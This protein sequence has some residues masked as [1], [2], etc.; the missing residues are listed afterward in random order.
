MDAMS[1]HD[2]VTINNDGMHLVVTRPGDGGMM[3]ETSRSIFAIDHANSGEVEPMRNQMYE[4]FHHSTSW[5]CGRT[6]RRCM[7][8][9]RT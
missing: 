1:T 2:G 9:L 7:P 3:M 4:T 6:W 8:Y 5:R